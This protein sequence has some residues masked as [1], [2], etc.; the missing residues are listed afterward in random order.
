M[1]VAAS[2]LLLSCCGRRLADLPAPL[3]VDQPKICEE[4]LREVA[5][6]TFGAEADAIGAFL[7]RDAATIEA[8]ER[9]KAGRACVRDQ[10]QD[11]AGQAGEP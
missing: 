7:Q 2:A 8:N 6:P 10:R 11:Y 4:I 5:R 9:I 3:R 1:A